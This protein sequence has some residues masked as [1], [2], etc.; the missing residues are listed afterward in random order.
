MPN[1]SEQSKRVNLSVMQKLE[2]IKK[3]EKSVSVASVCKQHSVK[4]QTISDIRKNKDKL[5]K[6][7]DLYCVDTLSFTSG[8][9]ENRKHI[10]TK[11]DQA[12]DAAIMKWYIQEWSSGVNICGVAIDHHYHTS[13]S[14][15]IH[16]F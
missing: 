7:A 11:K 10:K 9:V 8:K 3:L 4:K 14:S 15:W 13:C 2:V 1:Q 16:Q 12:L 6:Y 5:M